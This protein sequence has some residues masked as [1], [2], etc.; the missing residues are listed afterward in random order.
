LLLVVLLRRPEVELPEVVPLVEFIEPLVEPDML[1]EVLRPEV[2]PIEPEVVPIV[3]EVVPIEPLVEPE[4]LPIEP[5]VLPIEPE[6][7]PLVEPP[8][9]PAVVCANA[10]LLQPRVSKAARKI[11]EAF[12]EYKVENVK[13][14]KQIGGSI[15]ALQKSLRIE[16]LGRFQ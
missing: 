15:V 9:E 16:T 6:V 7:E 3:P 10:A 11:L 13:R 8:V 4:V 1:P 5:E 12:M 2:V 14:E